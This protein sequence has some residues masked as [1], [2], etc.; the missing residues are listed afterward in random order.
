MT[1]QTPPE[2]PEAPDRAAKSWRWSMLRIGELAR[3]TGVSRG[4]IQHYLR[5]GLLPVPV[6]TGRTMAY[7]DPSCVDR[8]LLIKDLQ[9]RYLPL[10]VIRQ[11]VETPNAPSYPVRAKSFP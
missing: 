2:R 8:I 10:G 11:L 3:R 7:Y 4:T 1:L 6:K 5:E 9:R